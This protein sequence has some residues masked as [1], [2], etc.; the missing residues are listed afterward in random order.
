L[1]R[2]ALESILKAVGE[3]AA[4]FK[5][6]PL[7]AFDT[8]VGAK[9]NRGLLIVGRAPNGWAA[10]WNPET[11]QDP[12]HRAEIARGVQAEALSGAECPM[13]WLVRDWHSRERYNTARSAF[14]RIARAVTER[15]R[16]AGEDSAD[17]SSYLAYT[18]LYRVSPAAAGN[19]STHL[20]EVQKAGCIDALRSDIEGLSPARILFLT[21]QD[22]AEPFLAKLGWSEQGSTDVIRWGVIY[23]RSGTIEVIEGPHPQAKPEAPL[24]NAIMEAWRAEP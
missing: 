15:L 20:R 21:G 19:P 8:L 9:W 22:W 5:D 11:I 10:A 4:S 14:W 3:R 6:R 1:R 7:T 18:N 16:L 23:G 17:W 12:V 24:V 2:T 13:S